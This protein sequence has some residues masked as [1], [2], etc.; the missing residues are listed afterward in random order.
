VHKVKLA[1]VRIPTVTI[2]PRIIASMTLSPRPPLPEAPV[3]SDPLVLSGPVRKGPPGWRGMN[4]GP[5]GHA[6]TMV[7][8][9]L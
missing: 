6:D 9:P 7:G 8:A 2:A 5:R 1:I 4:G 3:A